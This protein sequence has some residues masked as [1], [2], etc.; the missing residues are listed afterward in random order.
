MSE[1]EQYEIRKV[2][3]TGRGSYIT[4]LPKRWVESIGLK[5]GE[6]IFISQRNDNTLILTPRKVSEETGKKEFLLQISTDEDLE[7]LFRKVISLYLNGYSL[8]YLKSGKGRLS[9]EIKNY[10]R[11]RARTKLLGSEIV[12]ESEDT[13]TIQILLSHPELTVDQAFRR[14]L[15]IAIS[16]N[17]DVM[18]ALKNLDKALAEDV[19]RTE[20]EVDRFSFYIIRQLKLAI[21]NQSLHKELGLKTPRDI[22]GFRLMTKSVE[23]IADHVENIASNILTMEN[24]IDLRLYSKIEEM[25]SLANSL[26]LDVEKALFTRNYD[27]AE[28]ILRRSVKI[29]NLDQEA[30]DLLLKNQLNPKDV[31]RLRIILESVRRLIELSTDIAEVVLNLTIEKNN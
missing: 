16:M 24:K 19:I 14:I 5:Q 13:M 18:N 15:A 27:S 2:Q 20:D 3:V 30:M 21:Q 9:S 17:K 28:E 12:T 25:S 1:V 6:S 11:E 31:S 26:L 7:S 22:L 10:I 29:K 4:S 8:I 23:R